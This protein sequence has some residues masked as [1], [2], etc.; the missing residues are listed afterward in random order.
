MIR[1]PGEASRGKV[2]RGAKRGDPG[3]SLESRCE[4]ARR[5][6][7]FSPSFARPSSWGNLRSRSQ[8][9]DHSRFAPYRKERRKSPDVNGETRNGATTVKGT[10]PNGANSFSEDLAKKLERRYGLGSK[11]DAR[12][13][14]FKRLELAVQ[15]HG[16]RVWIQ[17]RTVAAEADSARQPDR[18]FCATALRRLREGGMMPLADL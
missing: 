1:Q 4:A 6:R 13:A 7:I 14:F 10:E 2:P 12:R 3:R 18:Y 17:I 11:A 8:P 5:Q 9:E 16:E 15:V